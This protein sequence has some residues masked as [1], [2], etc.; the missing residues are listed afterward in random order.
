MSLNIHLQEY[1]DLAV[2][3]MKKKEINNGKNEGCYLG[4]QAQAWSKLIDVWV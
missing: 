2:K 3:C 4:Y 1:Y